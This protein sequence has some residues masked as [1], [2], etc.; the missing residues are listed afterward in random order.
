MNE[1]QQA[2]NEVNSNK[3]TS[4]KHQKHQAM[5]AEHKRRKLGSAYKNA[6]HNARVSVFRVIPHVQ[7]PS[8]LLVE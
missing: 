7:V 5:L 6:G 4:T 3:R 8:S 1:L 2:I